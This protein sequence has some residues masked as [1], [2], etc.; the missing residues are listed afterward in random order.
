MLPIRT[1]RNKPW[2]PYECEVH[3]YLSDTPRDFDGPVTTVHG[4]FFNE[5]KQLLLVRHKKRGWE[6]PGGHIHQNES[7]ETAM[8]REL[9]EEAQMTSSDLSW[10]GYLKKEAVGPKPESCDYPYPLSYCIFFSAQIEKITP[11]IGDDSI[12]E[13]RFFSLEKAEGIPWII[14]YKDFFDEAI[15]KWHG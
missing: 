1:V 8:H 2:I 4:F 5:Q 9:W 10:V 14:E 13:A 6:I 7:I 12:K 15:K 11:F 3:S